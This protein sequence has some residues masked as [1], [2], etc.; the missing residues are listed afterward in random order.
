MKIAI[1]D[2]NGGKFSAD[3]QK[4]WEDNGHEVRFERGASE[5]LA[6][7]ADIYYVDTWDNNIH[8]L[9]KLYNGDEDNNR[10]KD[11]DNN[12][13]PKIVVRVLDWEVWIGWVRD[14]RIVDWV[15]QII[16]IAPHIQKRVASEVQLNGKDR[17]IKC[18]VNLEKFTLKTSQTDGYQLGMVLGDMWWPKNHMAGLDIFTQLYRKDNR[19]RLHIR[20]QHEPGEYWKV[21]YEHYLES[22]GIKEVV[23]LYGHVEDMNQW[24]E[25]IDVL[26]HPG[27]KE[28]F[29]YAVGEAMAKGIPAV[30]NEFYGS[31]DIWGI[32]DGGFSGLPFLY[33]THKEAINYL[34]VIKMQSQYYREWIQQHYSIE[35]MLKEF[36][37]FIGT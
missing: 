2:N 9:W 37:E 20:G 15:D 24:Y 31:R 22:R 21:M 25:Q 1:A 3:I 32:Q 36:D 17:V 7:W 18:G 33:Q 4:H 34:E 14:Q 5:H 27:M 29:C 28:A 8:Y 13:K 23:T 35:K 16:F 11:W 30:V 12:K 26:L 19:W 10:T 6:Q